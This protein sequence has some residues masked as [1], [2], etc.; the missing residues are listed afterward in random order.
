MRLVVGVW[1]WVWEEELDEERR[2][3][4]IMNGSFRSYV[5]VLGYF[6]DSPSRVEYYYD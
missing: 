1:A 6:H 4:D 5:E 2:G 3:G